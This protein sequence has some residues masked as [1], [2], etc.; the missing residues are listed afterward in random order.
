MTNGG[1]TEGMKILK[2]RNND[3]HDSPRK[4]KNE[5]G[6]NLHNTQVLRVQLTPGLAVGVA[7]S[8]GFWKLSSGN[9]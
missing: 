6:G 3:R 5:P 7:S 2:D 8:C 1:T 9:V 4:Q